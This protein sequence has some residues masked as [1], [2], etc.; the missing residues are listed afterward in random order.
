MVR[1]PR[2]PRRMAV[3][4]WLATGAGINWRQGNSDGLYVHSRFPGCGLSAVRVCEPATETV[5][6]AVLQFLKARTSRS[7]KMPM[8]LWPAMPSVHPAAQ[9]FRRVP[10]LT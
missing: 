10:R 7:K 5:D 3:A 6:D 8:Y 1:G 9:C 2:R 4:G